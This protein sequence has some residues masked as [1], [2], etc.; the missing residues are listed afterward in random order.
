MKIKEIS[1]IID[2]F[3]RDFVL[4]K[5]DSVIFEYID[6]EKEKIRLY[7]EIIK[8]MNTLFIPKTESIYFQLFGTNLYLTR[9]KKL[10]RKLLKNLNNLEKYK[11]DKKNF[12]INVVR[13]KGEFLEIPKCCIQAYIDDLIRI[14]IKIVLLKC[15]NEGAYA[16]KRYKRQLKDLKIK[17]PFNIGFNK[18]AI[19]Y[20]LFIPCSPICKKALKI[21]RDYKKLRRY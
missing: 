20:D 4:R 16:Y 6:Y 9:K 15:A 21:V 13:I 2:P 14:K 7:V 1:K 19:L 10:D 8:E 12:F 5:K 18:K 11:E 17:D 3:L